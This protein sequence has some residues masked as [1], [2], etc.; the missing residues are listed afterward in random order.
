MVGSGAEPEVGAPLLPLD[1]LP[2][3]AGLEPLALA[4]HHV[5]HD[6]PPLFGEVYGARRIYLQPVENVVFS[7][8]CAVSD[9]SLER[10]GFV[11]GG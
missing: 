7:L 9:R 4:E 10:Q 6:V 2:L 3:D 5:V 8:N 11:F 1:V